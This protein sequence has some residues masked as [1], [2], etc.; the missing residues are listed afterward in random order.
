LRW[1]CVLRRSP[2]PPLPLQQGL[3]IMAKNDP[4]M[5]GTSSIM[6]DGLSIIVLI[7]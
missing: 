7:M 2:F 6:R 1:R 3:I 4:R 5:Y